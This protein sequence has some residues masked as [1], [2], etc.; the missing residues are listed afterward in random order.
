MTG[1]TT[2]KAVGLS[3]RCG[4]CP[5]TVATLSSDRLFIRV[6]KQVVVTERPASVTCPRC[7]HINHLALTNAMPH[8]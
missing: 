7:G 3:I 5:A 4:Q 6:G 1:L 2:V 8:G